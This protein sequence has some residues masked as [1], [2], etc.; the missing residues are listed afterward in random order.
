MLKNGN[1]WNIIK[2]HCWKK[3][4]GSYCKGEKLRRPMIFIAGAWA[5]GIM[6]ASLLDLTIWI[7]ILLFLFSL[8]VFLWTGP[9]KKQGSILG[10]L[11]LFF[12]LFFLAAFSFQLSN[13]W[14][15][16]MEQFV[17]E[18][19]Q[20]KG[21][22]LEVKEKSQEYRQLKVAVVTK[23]NKETR[24]LVNLY[25]EAEYIGYLEGSWIKIKGEVSLPKSRRNP[26][27]FDYQL[28]LK[29]LGI[30]TIM[31]VKSYSLEI[32][33]IKEDKF[34]KNMAKLKGEFFIS[35]E[36]KIG[37][38][39][40]AM[41]K[42]MVFGDK[43]DLSEEVYVS[44]QKNGTAHILAASG[45]HL[46]VVYG[47]LCFLW[48]GKK[49]KLFHSFTL[50]A[51]L[52]YA[53]M[54]NFSPSVM[55]AT[56]MIVM[57]IVAKIIHQRYDLLSAASFTFVIMLV[58]NP[59]QL[60]NVGFQLSFLAIFTIGLVMGTIKEFYQ[61]IFLST[62]AIQ[63]GMAPY[64]AY[65][66][67]YF[68][69]GAF[70]ANVP[71]VFLAGIMI[72]LSLLT[73]FFWSI[74]E[75]IF[76][77]GAQ[78]LSVSGKAMVWINDLIFSGGKTSFQVVSP[79]LFFLIIYYGI[80]FFGVS[81]LGRIY[82]GRKNW[83]KL[84]LGLAIIVFCGLIATPL[85][86]DGFSKANIIF[87]D[88]GQ[89]DCIHIRTPEGKNFLI[90][91]GGSHNYDV[92]EK[93][94]KPY[95]L[96]NGVNKIDCAFVTHLHQDHYEGIVSLAKTGMIK[97]LGIYEGNKIKEDK[98][99]KE[100]QLKEKQ[101]LYI[102]GGQTV[103]LEKNVV[104]EILYPQGKPL[105]EYEETKEDENSS[106]LIIKVIYKG[107]SVMMTA[108]IDTEGEMQIIN[109]YKG[110]NKLKTDFLKVPHH[111]SK[112]S[113][114]DEFIKATSPDVAIFQV[115]KNNFGHPVPSI[116]EKYQQQCI[117]IYRNDLDGAIGL[118][119]L[120]KSKTPRIVTMVNRGI[121]GKLQ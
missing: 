75:F 15:D 101:L 23:D 43:T 4:V 90:D 115:G 99:L 14:E 65:L 39:S 117:M 46:G 73:M 2:R 58:V 11:S 13:T 22:V 45:L 91:G 87:V 26:K 72:P 27:T 112:Y 50:A 28:Y 30:R 98:I 95:L 103:N 48:P 20:V 40:A 18:V 80:L 83:K 56:I 82:I 66:F 70:I 119:D 49:G 17:G 57:H 1:I 113:S 62:V 53:A 34:K 96:K 55:R 94:L 64:T 100:T 110:S 12:C 7:I 71:I 52:L 121:D 6:L 116:I 31:T 69:F 120:S 114:S 41:I 97:Q 47:F 51:L 84:S 61:G 29:T 60:W 105:D 76:S 92:G 42:A 59:I 111:G 44:F 63:V 37:S 107:K 54:A 33:P 77:L 74:N 24:I 89:G 32:L 8:I 67:N 106:S 118:C 21:K 3:E 102:R 10:I 5:L 85:T 109:E 9:L 88:V 16:P 81:E 36:K 25:G 35:L 19:T 86:Q 78:M 93:E 108:D 68:S 104:L 79:S 38:S